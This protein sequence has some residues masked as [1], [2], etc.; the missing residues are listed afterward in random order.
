MIQILIITLN[1]SRWQGL[2]QVPINMQGTKKIHSLIKIDDA[3]LILKEQSRHL[4]QKRKIRGTHLLILSL[5]NCNT[6]IN[7]L[8]PISTI[9]KQYFIVKFKRLNLMAIGQGKVLLVNV[10][11]VGVWG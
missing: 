2:A 3:R 5:I 4:L 10:G 1:K 8:I 9:F 11:F 6:F 7:Q